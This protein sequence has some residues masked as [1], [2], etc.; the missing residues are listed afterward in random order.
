MQAMQHQRALGEAGPLVA[1]H[2]PSHCTC[3]GVHLSDSQGHHSDSV[4]VQAN[5][6]RDAF[7]RVWQGEAP[8]QHHPAR[9]CRRAQPGPCPCRPP[10]ACAPGALFLA[11]LPGSGIGA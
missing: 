6:V 10:S 5:S 7:G 3:T 1:Q 4:A 9:L 2:G 11:E 8:H